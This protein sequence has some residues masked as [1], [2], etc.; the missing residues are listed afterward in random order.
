M[1]FGGKFK[2]YKTEIRYFTLK[3]QSAIRQK[4]QE[5]WGKLKGN[6]EPRKINFYVLRISSCAKR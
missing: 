5:K 4:K 6:L 2:T 3:N 1:I